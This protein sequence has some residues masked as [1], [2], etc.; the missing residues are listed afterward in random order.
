[1]EHW[2]R[3]ELISE[4]KKETK[5]NVSIATADMERLAEIVS[6]ILDAI[7]KG[8]STGSARLGKEENPK[9]WQPIERG[10][11]LQTA[12]YHFSNRVKYGMDDELVQMD[13][14]KK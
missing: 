9:L 8:I 2:T 4:I 13:V 7:S 12:L 11:D 6:F 1:M 3:G 14:W 10:R 5:I